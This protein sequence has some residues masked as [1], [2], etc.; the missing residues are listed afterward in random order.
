VKKTIIT[1][2]DK[3]TAR[4]FSKDE[5]KLYEALQGHNIAPVLAN[6]DDHPTLIEWAIRENKLVNISRET[7]PNKS[8]KYKRSDGFWGNPYVEGEDG[9]NQEVVKKHKEW[10]L[11]GDGQHLLEHIEDLRGCVLVCNGNCTSQRVDKR[12]H[13]ELL[14]ELAAPKRDPF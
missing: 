13:G 1:I 8:P 3:Q 9:S 6:A 2:E 10:L 4:G 5:Q 14:V 11:S 7:S 12:C